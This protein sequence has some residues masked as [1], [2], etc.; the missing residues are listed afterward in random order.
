MLMAMTTARV[1]CLKT[2][3]RRANRL[4]FSRVLNSQNFEVNTRRRAE[5]IMSVDVGYV[6]GVAKLSSDRVRVC[7]DI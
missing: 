1:I 6:Y 3:L 2:L 7:S 5:Q 4:N